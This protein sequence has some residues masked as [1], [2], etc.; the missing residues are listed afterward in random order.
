MDFYSYW[1]FLNRPSSPSST[2]RGI[3]ALPNL[4]RDT[5]FLVIIFSITFSLITPIV[6][7]I[8]SEKYLALTKRKKHELPSYVLCL[9]HHI[10]AVPFA[11]SSLYVDFNL[12][13][14]A[15]QNIDYAPITAVI[16]PWCI[17]YLISDTLLF[18]LPEAFEGKFDYVTHHFLT[19]FL[20]LSSLVGPGS[21]LRFIPLFLISDTTN[22]YFNTA[23]LMRLFGWKDSTAVMI[24]EICFSV[25]FLFVRVIN[26]PMVFW[27]VGSQPQ[28]Q[29]LG[30]AR[31]ALAPIALL[32]WY[33]FYLIVKIMFR[34]LTKDSTSKTAG[35]E[36][37]NQDKN[38]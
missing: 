21:I 1:A 4:F 22:L 31:F 6:S 17:A 15:A 16:A 2:T 35:R 3:E 23:W 7:R 12:S 38:L 26:M 24:L 10:V 18:A 29:E 11:W 36:D 5:V 20:V 14:E 27:A 19:L 25:S 37:L 34:R 32:Q 13:S 30:F 33:W 28:I 8:S 9:I